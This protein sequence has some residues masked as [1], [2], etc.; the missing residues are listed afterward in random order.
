MLRPLQKKLL[1]DVWHMRGQALA[2]ALVVMAGV[3]MLVMYFSTFDSLQRTL[4]TY[5]QR[6]GF[7]DV[8]ASVRR[9]PGRLEERL[10]LLPGVAAVE[11]RVVADVTLDVPAM[12]EPAIGRLVSVP[13]DARPRLN[14]V[15]L[16]RGRWM[17]AGRPD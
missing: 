3:A 9:A 13:G 17:E 2:I 4:D 10:A 11:T 5:Y 8:F 6:H 1:R 16:R 14:G 12:K 7:A 15:V